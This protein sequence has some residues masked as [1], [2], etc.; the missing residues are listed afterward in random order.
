MANVQLHPD[1]RA[2]LNA[3]FDWYLERSPSAA[4]AF[5]VQIDEAIARIEESPHSWP[6]YEYGTR[7]FLVRVYP[8][9]V[10]YLEEKGNIEII[11][12]AHDKRKPGYWVD[13][14]G[15]I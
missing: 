7:R 6:P 12:V 11:A 10:V 13:R 1:A 14:V 5:L 8:F 9:H 15:A 3:A 4:R 2:E